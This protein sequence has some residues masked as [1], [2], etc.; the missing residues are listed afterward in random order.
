MSLSPKPTPRGRDPGLG[1]AYETPGIAQKVTKE[2]KIG[3]AGETGY[4]E[5][6]RHPAA[7]GIAAHGTHGTPIR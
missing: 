5:P 1:R 4:F 6:V 3:E 7:D 2:T